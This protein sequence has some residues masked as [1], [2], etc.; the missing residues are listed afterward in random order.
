MEILGAINTK[1][2]SKFNMSSDEKFYGQKENEEVGQDHG[3]CYS[4]QAGL[5]TLTE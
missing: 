3:K 1:H 4:R 5:I 2:T